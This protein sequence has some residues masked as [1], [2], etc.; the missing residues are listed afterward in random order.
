MGAGLYDKMERKLKLE[1]LAC[2]DDYR[3]EMIEK[4]EKRTVNLTVRKATES[5]RRDYLT[6][7]GKE[8]ADL[9][10]LIVHLSS[11]H[12]DMTYYITDLKPNE[13]L[14]SRAERE[15][16]D[17]HEEWEKLDRLRRG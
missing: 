4:G 7:K 2:P 12:T 15:L 17:L 5:E 6:I 10:V 1:S 8:P 16:N 14:K 13:S 3:V 9:Y 11:I